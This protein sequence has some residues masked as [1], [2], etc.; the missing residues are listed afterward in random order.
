VSSP[1]RWCG[2]P[3]T[4]KGKSGGWLHTAPLAEFR[5]SRRE[6]QDILADPP[7]PG[8]ELHRQSHIHPAQ[9]E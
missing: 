6:L 3:V 9:P 8:L 4:F 7:R 1:C 5:I 2:A